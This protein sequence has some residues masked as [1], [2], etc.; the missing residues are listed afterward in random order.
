MYTR[1]TKSILT[2]S[3][4]I[5]FFNYFID[6]REGLCGRYIVGNVLKVADGK[7]SC[8]RQFLLWKISNHLK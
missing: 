6:L 8:F 7:V 2:A 5:G 3:C 4:R 1:N